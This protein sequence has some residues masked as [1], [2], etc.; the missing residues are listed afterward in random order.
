MIFKDKLTVTV[1]GSS[2]LF[3]Y[4][5]FRGNRIMSLDFYEELLKSERFCESLG[6]LILMSGKL[7]SALKSVVLTANIQVKYDLERAMLGQ[8]ASTC[9]SSELVTDELSEILSF[10][11]VRRNYLTHKL[12]PHFNDEIDISLLPTI[13]LEPDDAEYSFPRYVEDLLS[14][15][16][17]AIDYLNE[18]TNTSCV[19]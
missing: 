3:G 19:C 10:I 2:L 15:I 16:E 8:L 18:K 5:V 9:K 4:Y 12:Y 1:F 6:R 11:I 7:E 13:N 14:Y 17:F